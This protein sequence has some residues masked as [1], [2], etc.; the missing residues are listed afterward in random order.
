MR[1]KYGIND[2]LYKQTENFIKYMYKTWIFYESKKSGK[3]IVLFDPNE[4]VIP[5]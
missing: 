3:Q 1:T 4:W 5:I 2:S